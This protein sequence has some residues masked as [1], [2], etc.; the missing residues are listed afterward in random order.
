MGMSKITEPT[1][2]VV[3]PDPAT[4][5]TVHSV[6]SGLH[7]P[8]ESFADGLDF[9]NSFEPHRPGCLLLELRIPGMSGLMIQER[10]AR[11]SAI[12]PLIFL[13]RSPSVSVAIHVMRAGALHFFEKPLHEHELWSVI[14]E[15]VQIDQERRQS[16]SETESIQ[17]QLGRL[18]EIEIAVL[19][20]LATGKNKR[21]IAEELDKSVRTV[22]H[23]RTQLMRKLK[24]NSTEALLCFAL[25]AEQRGLLGPTRVPS[26]N[27]EKNGFHKDNNGFAAAINSHNGHNLE[28]GAWRRAF[29]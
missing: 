24:M 25:A 28:T 5:E 6:A 29:Q 10:L 7:L 8:C 17:M 1:V 3:D 11:S 2:F 27:H 4:R 14:Q 9:V 16:R 23:H 26:K 13:A 19:E 12:L 18:S 21:A 20:L 15:A 22:D